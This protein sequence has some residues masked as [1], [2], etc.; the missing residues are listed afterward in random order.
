MILHFL[1]IFIFLHV[2]FKGLK[3][4]SYCF[5]VLIFNI[6]SYIVILIIYYYYYYY[7]ELKNWRKI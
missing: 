3:E 6:N 1:A 4:K 5:F 7:Y 2:G